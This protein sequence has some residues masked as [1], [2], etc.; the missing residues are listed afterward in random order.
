MAG[1][2]SKSREF[3]I[4]NSIFTRLTDYNIHQVFYENFN[5]PEELHT[6]RAAK[7]GEVASLK[8]FAMACQAAREEIELRKKRK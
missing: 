3:S 4:L 7:R 5:Q 6:F 1:L 2:A 8:G